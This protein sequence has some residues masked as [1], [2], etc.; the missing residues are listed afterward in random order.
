MQALCDTLPAYGFQTF[1]CNSGEEALNALRTQTFDLM[2]TDLMMPGLDGIGLLDLARQI[3][4]DLVAVVMTGEGTIATAVGAMKAG[5]LDYVLKPFKASVALPVLTRSLEV[6]RLRIELSEMQRRERD[7]VDELAQFFSVSKDLL[8][9]AG[10]DGYFK[11]IN[12]AWERTL[13]HS[14]QTLRNRPFLEFVH[15]EDKDLTVHEMRRLVAGGYEC[16]GFENRYLHRDGSYRWIQ[17]STTCNGDLIYAAARDVTD[18]KQ[19]ADT[20]RQAKQAAEE[21]NRAKSEFL[22]RM[23]HELRTPLNAILGFAQLLEMRYDDPQITEAAR[24]ILKGG[25]HLLQMINEVLDLARIESGRM[26]M[27]IESVNAAEVLSQ[28]VGLVRPLAETAGIVLFVEA[29]DETSMAKADRQRLIQV[30][31]NLLSNAIKYNKPSGTVRVRCTGESGE[32]LRFEVTDE[33]RG[34]SEEDREMLFQPFQRFGDQSIE[35]TGLGLALSQ[36][37][38]RQMNGDL[39]LLQSSSGGSTFCIE[40]DRMANRVHEL[41]VLEGGAASGTP[42]ERLSGTVLYVE[43]NLSN[44]R[45]MEVLF[46]NSDRLTLVPATQGQMGLEFAREHK[47]DLILLDLHLPDLS[48]AEVLLKLKSDPAT[49]SVPVTILSADASPATAAKL[50]AAGADEYLTKP[51]D[52]ERLFEVLEK[53]LPLA[54]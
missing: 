8:C 27:S 1:G 48:G 10:K 49:Q 20:L 13:G 16:V 24:F 2:L 15:P 53:H 14:E 43:D 25:R 33:G 38:V 44:I 32:K 29:L 50:L 22:S 36:R 17:W 37:F 18:Q 7:K 3:D 54:A 4:P 52:L 6:R 11:Q 34:I 31:I 42:L 45:L 26:N 5:A 30:L 35:G 21:G 47:P 46:A 39:I 23:S 51:L 28:A 41:S 9:I 40:L 12:K 19:M